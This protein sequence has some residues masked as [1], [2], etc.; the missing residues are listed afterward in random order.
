MPVNDVTAEFRLLGQVTL[1]DP[2]QEI[3]IS[4]AAT[5]FGSSGFTALRVNLETGDGDEQANDQYRARLTIPS[6]SVV[7]LDLWNGVLLNPLNQHLWFTHIKSVVIAIVDPDGTKKV[8]VGPQGE[9]DAAQLWFGG[10]S[11]THYEEVFTWADHQHP[12]EGWPLLSTEYPGSVLAISN[13]NG[14]T[15]GDVQVDVCIVGLNSD[16]FTV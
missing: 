5:Q 8:L 3:G 10:V 15:V 2:N 11:L 1:D 12:Y 7:L 14:P 4:N 13:P 9:D 6:G 16:E